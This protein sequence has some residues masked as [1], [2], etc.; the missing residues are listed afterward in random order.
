MCLEEPALAGRRGRVTARIAHWCGVVAACTAL[1][2]AVSS[3]GAGGRLTHGSNGFPGTAGVSASLLSPGDVGLSRDATP[4][5]VDLTETEFG[6]RNLPYTSA[7]GQVVGAMKTFSDAEGGASF[8]KLVS[9]A[10]AFSSAAAADKYFAYVRACFAGLKTVELVPLPGPLGDEV[11]AYRGSQ[12]QLHDLL[13]TWRRGAWVG[14]LLDTN[15][16][17]PLSSVVYALSQKQ[18]SRMQDHATG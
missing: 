16:V 10:I 4:V 15:T 11:A 1:A 6:C 9:V 12:G 18:E 7:K 13:V 8:L 3:C 2:V 17:D 14:M 5:A